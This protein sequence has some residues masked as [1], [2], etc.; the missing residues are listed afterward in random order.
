MSNGNQFHIAA[1]LWRGKKPIRICCNSNKTRKGFKRYYSN[2]GCTHCTHAEM[3]AC[4]YAKPGDRIT[5]MRFHK[6]GECAIAK[7]CVFCMCH[8]KKSGIRRVDYTDEC[9][10]FQTLILQ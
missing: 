7:P 6:N 10:C 3:E 2:G 9:G 1:I 8:L 4:V 5:V